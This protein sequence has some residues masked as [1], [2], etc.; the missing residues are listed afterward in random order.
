MAEG[1]LGSAGRELPVRGTP[2]NSGKV[3]NML[4]PQG[5]Q[6]VGDPTQCHAVA[7]DA[8]APK[9]DGGIITRLDCVVF[10][11]VVNKH[12][13][14]STTRARMS[15]RS[16]TRS[17]AAWSPANPTRSPTSSSTRPR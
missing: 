3:L 10:G 12:A 5:V 1:I 14:A 17:G 11:I 7:I 15:G 13:S 8:R 6:T 2:Y 9:F 4:L 16:A